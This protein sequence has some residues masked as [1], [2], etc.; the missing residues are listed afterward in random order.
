MVEIYKII[1]LKTLVPKFILISILIFA[2]V[3]N[4]NQAD[5]NQVTSFSITKPNKE[6]RFNRNGVTEYVCSYDK[7]TWIGDSVLSTYSYISVDDSIKFEINY[8]KD[9]VFG[10]PFVFTLWDYDL[11]DSIKVEFEFVKPPEIEYHYYINNEEVFFESDSSNVVKFKKIREKSDEN[12]YLKAIFFYKG[13]K[14]KTFSRKQP[15]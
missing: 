2:C 5:I 9:S 13:K 10:M 7:T 1:K 11:R 3:N 4:L 14:W 6:R 8:L 12:L 15:V